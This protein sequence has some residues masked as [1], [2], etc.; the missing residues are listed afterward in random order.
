MNGD[1]IKAAVIGHPV[2]H[3]KSPLIHN[4]WL[5]KYGIKGH[6][7]AIDVPPE[8]LTETLLRL[9]RENYT[10]FNIT[11]PHKEAVMHRCDGVDALAK[12]I[13]AV[14]LVTIENG[15]LMGTNSDA[16]GFAGAVRQEH[17]DFDFTRGSVLV[18]GAGGAT[19]AV[20]HALIDAGAPDIRLCNRT[21]DKA[22]SVGE[23]CADPARV[24]VIAW[25]DR[26]RDLETINMLVNTTSLG[27]AGQPPLPMDIGALNK[28]ALVAD[29]VYKPLKTDLLNRAEKRGNKICGGIGMLLHQ[30]R[31]AFQAWFGIMPE[32]D[33]TLKELVSA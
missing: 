7:E 14:N 25:E 4:Y 30:A 27:M 28:N 17:P 9:A 12:S 15:R 5:K 23:G 29:I 21:K 31:P 8:K 16:F 20:L 32:I 2:S 3:S 10:G 22:L 26:E 1:F 33:E 19:R 24:K 6:Y 18:L 11:L 13:G